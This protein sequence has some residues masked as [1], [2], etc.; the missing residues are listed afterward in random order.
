MNISNFGR[1]IGAGLLALGLHAIAPSVGAQ[2]MSTT[3]GVSATVPVT[4]WSV[5]PARAA[6]RSTASRG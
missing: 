6:A 5:S 2:T 1:L 3:G 4:A